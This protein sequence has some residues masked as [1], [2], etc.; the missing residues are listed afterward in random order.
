MK[1]FHVHVNVDQLDRS[2]R[3]YTTLFGVAPSVLKPDYA[4]WM[5]DDP[6][7]NFAIS[8]RGRQA[9][10]DHLGVQAEDDAELAAIGARLQ[11]ADAV[12]LAERATTC[13]Y[14]R[15]DKFWAEDP[16]GVRWES[17][18]TH[19][20]ATTYAG[21]AQESGAACC[22]P[23]PSGDSAAACCGPAANCC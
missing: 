6:R 9:G 11:A 10:V 12:A 18:R 17:F 2:I 1:R 14:A 5:L 7:V 23:A 20:E 13:C 15:S 16:Q 4:K 8:Q 22:G 21:A 3:F 19:G